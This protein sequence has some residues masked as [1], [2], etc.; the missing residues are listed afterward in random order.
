MFTEVKP[1]KRIRPRRKFLRINTPMSFGIF[2]A[3][4]LILIGGGTYGLAAGVIAPAVDRAVE[5]NATPSPT[6]TATPVILTPDPAV[7]E[8]IAQG[9][10]T[11]IDPVTGIA[12]TVSPSLEPTAI[13]E[14]TAT[15]QPLAGRTI[16][17]DA[18]KS[19]GGEHRG[20]SSKTYEYKINYWFADA[21]RTELIAQGATVI[22]TRDGESK[23][24]SAESRLRTINNSKA[25][26]VISLFCNDLNDSGV[27]GAEAFVP[28]SSSHAES[29]TKLARAVLNGYTTATSMPI[30]ETGEGTIRVTSSKEVLNGS[31]KPVMGLVLGQLSNRSDDANLNDSAFIARAARGIANGIRS[32]F[33]S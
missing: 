14:P 10:A 23:S 4:L 24:V 19:K 25:D 31:K 7:Q 15:P 28:K 22:M 26:I 12:V 32:Y 29:D 6:P 27:R 13:P 8:A 2:C 30:R 9:A 1:V 21:L 5:A 11:T 18:G 3:L 17:I 33:A 20:V 16:A